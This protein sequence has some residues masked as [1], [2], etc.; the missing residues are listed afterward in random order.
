[1]VHEMKCIIFYKFH[2][3]TL[4]SSSLHLIHCSAA[5]SNCAVFSVKN[6]KLQKVR[7]GCMT[8]CNAMKFDVLPSILVLYFGWQLKFMLE[9]KWK[10]R[11]R[12][13]ALPLRGG[14]SFRKYTLHFTL[15]GRCLLLCVVHCK[16]MKF[17]C[18]LER[19]TKIKDF[20]VITS[21]I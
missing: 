12:Q 4:T 5:V 13:N 8:P 7:V 9:V 20:L 11:M 3:I 18:I 14:D 19:T 16:F 17:N 21:I 6:D 15:R 10:D 1:M 2:F